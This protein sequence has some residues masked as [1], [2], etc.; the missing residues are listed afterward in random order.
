[1][2][3]DRTK[4]HEKPYSPTHIDN[5][6]FD[7]EFQVPVAESLGYD[8]QN[9]QRLNASNMAIKITTVNAVTYLAMAAPGTDQSAALWQCRKIDESTGLV[10]TWADGDSNFD[11]VATDLTALDYS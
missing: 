9:L 4:N 3:I 2:A 1:M 5:M 7:P 10:V 8:G 6:G 11:N